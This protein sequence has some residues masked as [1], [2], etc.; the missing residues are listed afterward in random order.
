MLVDSNVFCGSL[1]VADPYSGVRYGDSSF[2]D[3]NLI[4]RNQ[5][6]KE[7]RAFF[8]NLLMQNEKFFPELQLDAWIE[9]FS[10]FDLQ[11]AED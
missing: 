10:K 4:L 2:R 9:T 6:A 3:L 8:L 7:I 1:N 11:F 5:D